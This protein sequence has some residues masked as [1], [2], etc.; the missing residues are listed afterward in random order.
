MMTEGGG[1]ALRLE[2]EKT[3]RGEREIEQGVGRKPI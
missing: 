1:R 2:E 3:K